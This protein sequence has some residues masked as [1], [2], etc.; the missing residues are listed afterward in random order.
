MNFYHLL[1]V[2]NKNIN[3]P[4]QYQESVRTESPVVQPVYVEP[5]TTPTVKQECPIQCPR[6]AAGR[7]VTFENQKLCINFNSY[8]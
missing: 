1:A 7:D 3:F 8:V 6:G 2:F 4:K 5:T